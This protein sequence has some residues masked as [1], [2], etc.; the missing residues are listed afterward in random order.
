MLEFA[1]AEKL[2]RQDK[3]GLLSGSHEGLRYLKLRS[4]SRGSYLEAL[5]GA[6]GIPVPEKKRNLFETVYRSQ[7]SVVQIDQFIRTT[8]SAEREKRL[9]EEDA[10]ISELY[11]IETF[12]WSGSDQG[13]LEK[14][15]VDNFI[16]KIKVYAD[17]KDAVETQIFLNLQN[18]VYS[19]WYNHWTSIVIEDLV[20]EQPRVLPAVGLV[21]KIDF[22]IDDVPFDLKVTYL[23][24]G[25][26]AD[27][28]RT[29]GIGTEI[30]ALKKACRSVG[31]QLKDSAGA[32]LKA[33]VLWQ[34][35]DDHPSP[36]AEVGLAELR[37]VRNQILTEAIQQ[38]S[39]LAKWLYE[40]Q[41]ERRFDS[42]NRL[43]IVLVDSH[44]FFESWKLK[45]AKSLIKGSI[46]SFL[47]GKEGA[48]GFDL[49]F[50]WEGESFSVTT[51]IIFV[52]K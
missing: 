20:K 24:E 16:K 40:N 31:I 36:S 17:L 44:S 27:W 15:I 3:I 28:R 47:A 30:T 46:E 2:F 48:T 12:G 21:K 39:L 51:D 10:L 6:H 8:F 37:T 7:V 1:E 29:Q 11:K 45:R 23:P 38:P 52:V 42:S 22:F 49:T 41:G 5:A 50:D 35:L 32:D 19:S 9:A 34:Q 18:Y 13:G 26:V 43:F 4:L 14:P 25:Y 33:P